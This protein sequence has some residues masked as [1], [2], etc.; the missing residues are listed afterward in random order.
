MTTRVTGLA[1]G[2]NVDELVTNSMKPYK[3]KVDSVKQNKEIL[4]IR[5]KLYRDIISQGSDLYDKYLNIAKSD[6]LLSTKNYITTTFDSTN[7]TVATA[8]ALDST[9]IKDNYKVD[10]TK[11]AT[12]ANTTIKVGDFDTTT[13]KSLTF[14][15]NGKDVTVDLSS[16]LDNTTYVAEDKNRLIAS[17]LNDQLSSL[18]LKATYSDI[19]GGVYIESTSAGSKIGTNTNQFTI[20]GS[21][22]KT[23]SKGS[24]LEATI[25]SSKGTIKYGDPTIDPTAQVA[26]GNTATVEGIK[27]TFTDTTAASG[28]VTLV[29]KTDV[30]AAKEKIIK[31][32][33]DYNTMVQNM[34]K[35][36]NE[37]RN[38]DYL[39]LTDDQKKEMKEN[40][41]TLWNKKVEQ[42]QL[43]RDSDV[44]K[45]VNDMKNAIG[46]SVID[47][48]TTLEKI[49]IKPIKDYTTKNGMF[50]VNEEELTKALEE[51]PDKVMNLF[52]QTP[53]DGTPDSEKTSKTGIINR[54]KNIV[55]DQTVS[56][57]KSALIKK[58]GKSDSDFSQNTLSKSISDYEKKIKT[59][60]K[61]LAEREQKF[62]SKYASLEKAMNS[63]NAQMA[64]LSSAFGTSA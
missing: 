57:T 39:P 3:A 63:Y 40:E 48:G 44:S 30:T 13:T 34:N 5:Q 9:A 29:G 41:I 26:N 25:T 17:T 38:R 51:N 18:G 8:K 15:Y 64:Q 12:T 42:G 53:P 60:T 36:V 54:L 49:G 55:Y 2:L 43:S 46:N 52:I 33:N 58:A 10:V 23:S 56:I 24:N 7:S 47:S 1:S 16:I 59:M 45:L 14:S 31:F 27:F 32:F 28:T 6:T 19:A 37:K 20:A 22:S 11:L 4:E 35:L 21:I 62:Y 61:D 50:E